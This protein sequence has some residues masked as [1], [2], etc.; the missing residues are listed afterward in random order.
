[1]DE[2]HLHTLRKNILCALRKAEAN[3]HSGR[4]INLSLV[5]D[6]VQVFQNYLTNHMPAHP[7]DALKELVQETFL[8]IQ[9]LSD[10]IGEEIALNKRYSADVAASKKVMNAYTYGVKK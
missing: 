5:A 8:D 1:M 7:S 2:K 3:L 6:H 9:K 10:Q 4:E